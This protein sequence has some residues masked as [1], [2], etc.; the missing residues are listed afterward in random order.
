MLWHGVSAPIDS[1]SAFLCSLCHKG[2]AQKLFPEGGTLTGLC[3]FAFD[4]PSPE[5]PSI[6]VLT[7]QVT[8]LLLVPVQMLPPR[9]SLHPP[10][11]L[12]HQ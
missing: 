5:I 3:A 6:H 7:W 2:T 12:E 4:V 11:V 10:E 8:P 1:H 9:R